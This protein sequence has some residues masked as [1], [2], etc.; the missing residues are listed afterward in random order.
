MTSMLDMKTELKM[1]LNPPGVAIVE[2]THGLVVIS[3]ENE[4]YEYDSIQDAIEDWGDFLT[5][6]NPQ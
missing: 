1:L 3:D 2:I 6:M 4:E 5:R